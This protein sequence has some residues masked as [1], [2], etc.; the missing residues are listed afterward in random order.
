MTESPLRTA[1]RATAVALMALFLAAAGP[2]KPG[3]PGV[4]KPFAGLKPEAVFEIGKVAD[5][6]AIT[7]DSVSTLEIDTADESEI[8]A[9][10][11]PGAP[12]IAEQPDI[13]A[14]DASQPIGAVT[15]APKKGGFM[16]LLLMILGITIIA[17]VVGALI[18]GVVLW[19]IFQ[20]SESQ[21]LK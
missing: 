16:R 9:R 3:V 14:D 2:P 20:D 6:V 1:V 12:L 5:W 13:I 10:S 8:S 19:Y 4:Q 11:V 15:T 17:I 21:N 18:T 7:P